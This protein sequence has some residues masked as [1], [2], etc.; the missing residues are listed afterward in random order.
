VAGLALLVAAAP[1]SAKQ[2]TNPTPILTQPGDVG[3]LLPYP[4]VIAVNGIRGKVVSA[5]VTLHTIQHNN[6]SELDVLLEG[7]GGRAM[8]MSNVCRDDDGPLTL[9]FDDAASSLVPA[10]PG[11]VSGAYKPTNRLPFEFFAHPVPPGPYANT[12]SIFRNGTPN[13]LWQL[14]ATDLVGAVGG[15]IE[16]GWTL[17][18]LTSKVKTCKKPK[19]KK[20]G[21]AA[22]RRC[23]K[24]RR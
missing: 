13:G 14:Y 3:A 5:K 8:L 11:C 16:G 15:G 2:F 22:K 9:T 7:P 12:L 1:A 17:D 21:S 19:G 6:I 4:S 20:A 24:K 18:L 23:K 10:D